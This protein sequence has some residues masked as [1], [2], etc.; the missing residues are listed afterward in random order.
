MTQTNS[1][2]GTPE[3]IA[4]EQALNPS[5][6]DIR[7]D[8]Y[9]LGCCMYF[10]LTGMPPCS[11]ETTLAILHAHLNGDVKPLRELRPDLPKSIAQL[12]Q[13][14]MQKS[15]EKRFQT[16]SDLLAAI[17]KIQKH[18]ADLADVE[19]APPA[20]TTPAAIAVE[21]SASDLF[22]ALSAAPARKGRN[23]KISDGVTK[24]PAKAA[25]STANGSSLW[26]AKVSVAGR[27][28]GILTVV[29]ISLLLVS[30]IVGLLVIWMRMD[31]SSPDDATILIADLPA[32]VE[33]YV[34][35]KRKSFQRE[36]NS[37]LLFA[38]TP[39]GVTVISFQ[40]AGKEVNKQQVRL[41]K[42]QR[43]TIKPN[44]LVINEVMPRLN[45]A[46][47]ENANRPETPDNSSIPKPE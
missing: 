43:A 34:N 7:A 37:D 47:S 6:A 13:L 36:K 38:H 15:V 16:P 39:P 24:K 3:Y 25:F 19:N 4:P 8:I 11:G 32:D 2:L 14:M 33:V 27:K 20:S 26:A 28:I 30:L 5:K 45:E 46:G 12:Q 29:S 35:G 44:L 21:S 9:S 17:R 22:T 23:A 41:I 1:I 42:Q 10:A 40:R 31:A 18:L